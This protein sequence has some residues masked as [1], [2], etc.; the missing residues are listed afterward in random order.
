MFKPSVL[1]LQP[2]MPHYRLP[3]FKRVSQ[4]P[5]MS[6]TTAF[7]DSSPGSSLE[8]IHGQSH[9]REIPLRN[10]HFWRGKYLVFQRGLLRHVLTREFDV[11][12]A[13]FDIHVIS[14]IISFILARTLGIRFV[15]WGHGIGPARHPLSKIIRLWLCRRSDGVVFYNAD[16]ADLFVSWGI[17][18]EKTHVA[19]NSI[20]TEEIDRLARGWLDGDRHRII[21]VGR[22]I[23]EK[24]VELLVKA[25]TAA[26]PMLDPRTQLT[27]VGD[28][29]EK[30]RLMQMA[31]EAGLEGRIEFAGALYRQE[32]LAPLFNTAQVSV[33]PGG[34][35]L[36][37]IHSLAY[38]V[39]LIV[40]DN[41]PHGP[42][43]SAVEK[44]KTGLF[45]QSENVQEL[46]DLLVHIQS[47]HDMLTAMSAQ[48]RRLVSEKFTLSAM[49]G[50]FENLLAD[51]Y[52]EDCGTARGTGKVN[53]KHSGA[54]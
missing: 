29:P 2:I 28:G 42:E 45:F 53:P 19:W 41:E 26:C 21:S 38:G 47:Q 33:C 14:S 10:V 36:F 30:G 24:K 15:W 44:G 25:F 6:P 46:R 16:L 31:K 12:I 4:S 51:L 39:P 17:R 27:I 54:T 13:S 50:V 18:R 7:G 43:I 35:G 22:L 9:M 23:P 1:F 20:D 11:I 5:V 49:V 34:I 32:D 3:L 8:S 52:P 40:A 37:A 48:A